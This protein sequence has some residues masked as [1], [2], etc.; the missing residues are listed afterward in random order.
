MPRK[1]ITPFQ[2]PETAKTDIATRERY[3][4]PTASLYES[5]TIAGL[6]GN[7]FKLYHF[8]MMYSGAKQSFT[9]SQKEAKERANM[10]EHTFRRAIKELEAARLIMV[11]HMGAT[12]KPNIIHWCNAWKAK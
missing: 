4:R 11:E 6:S 2:G 7:A 5:E 8:M 10:P 1:K 3:I 9:F 12:R